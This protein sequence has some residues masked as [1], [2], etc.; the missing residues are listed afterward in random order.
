MFLLLS[1]FNGDS[2]LKTVVSNEIA[3]LTALYVRPI[4]DAPLRCNTII[5]E[6]KPKKEVGDNFTI[7][8][9]IILPG[10]MCKRFPQIFCFHNLDVT[11]KLQQR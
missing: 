2:K 10:P 5:V 7:L 3:F 9:P 6:L 8:R 11:W 1:D 4:Q